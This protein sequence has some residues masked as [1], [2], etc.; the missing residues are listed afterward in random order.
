MARAAQP[1]AQPLA[2][3]L[4]PQQLAQA[5][6]QRQRANLLFLG[7]KI[8]VQDQ[9]RV[10]TIPDGYNSKFV[11]PDVDGKAQM[12]VIDKEDQILPAF[13]IVTQGR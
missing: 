13:Q 7:H 5:A 6:A 12:I 11:S 1:T 2:Q 4:A 10:R 9:D 3:A 8:R